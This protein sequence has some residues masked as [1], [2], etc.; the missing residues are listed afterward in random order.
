MDEPPSEK[1]RFERRLERI[2][3]AR[4]QPINDKKRLM[5]ACLSAGIAALSFY[6]L[7]LTVGVTY[8]SWGMIAIVLGLGGMVG[9]MLGAH[10]V[11]TGF[12]AGLFAGVWIFF[13]VIMLGFVLFVE[14]FVLVFAGIFS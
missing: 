11:R 6:T 14:A 4:K 3:N 9:L 10:S 1:N 7:L 13:E 2:K 5:A 12:A 8:F